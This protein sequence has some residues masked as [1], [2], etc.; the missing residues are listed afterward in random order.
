MRRWAWLMAPA[1]VLAVV[2]AAVP[3]GATTLPSGLEVGW[4]VNG[5][6]APFTPANVTNTCEPG[7]GGSDATQCVGNY[8][9]AGAALTW[10]VTSD[11]DPFVNSV[12][13][14]TNNTAFPQTYILTATL[15]IAPAIPG[16]TLIGGSSQITVNDSNFSGAATVTSVL[17]GT[18]YVYNA[19]ID[20][21]DVANLHGTGFTLSAPFAGGGA[22]ANAFFGLPGPTQPGPAALTSIGIR[23]EIT[24]SAGDSV[25][26]NSSFIVIPV[27]E[28]TTIGLVAL[29]I[30]GLAAVGRR[31]SD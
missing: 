7:T 21:A 14:F 13:G 6:A 9:W 5:A 27:P 18:D 23:H 19:L 17:S 29:G 24:L 3:A 25:T 2:L 28:S 8:A 12:F 16:A 31:R 11:P 1:L 22:T 20:G 30:A 26:L 10:N 4:S 15:P